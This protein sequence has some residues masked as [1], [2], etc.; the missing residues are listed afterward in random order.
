MRVALHT[1]LMTAILGSINPCVWC[2]KT[3]GDR[4][5]NTSE[6]LIQNGSFEIEKKDGRAQNWQF[7]GQMK[8]ASLDAG[9]IIKGKF[10]QRTEGTAGGKYTVSQKVAVPPKTE[11]LFTAYVRSDDRVVA[12]AGRLAMSYHKQGQWQKISG[13]IRSGS[14]NSVNITFRIGGLADKPVSTWIDNVVLQPIERPKL[15]PRKTFGKTTLVESGKP[16]TY[17]IY[18]SIGKY[19]EPAQRL[20]NIIGLHT[21]CEI[22]VIS[23]VEATEADRP[24]LKKL[25][26][27]SNLI[28]IGR[29]GINRAMWP[30]YGRFL[31]ATDGYYPGGDGYVVRTAA[32]VMHNGKN[33]LILGGSSDLGVTRA[34]ERFIKIIKD[35]PP[36]TGGTFTLPWLLDVG[37]GGKCKKRFEAENK[38]WIKDPLNKKLH[39]TSPPN[40]SAY[41]IVRTWYL[42]A[43]GYYWTGWPRY[44]QRALEYLKPVLK[45]RARTHHYLTEF[46][47]RTYD[48][49][50]DGDLFT[51]E[52]F[53]ALDDLVFEDFWKFLL[54]GDLDRMKAF[55]P[56]YNN[57]GLINRHEISPWTA[58]LKMAEFLHKYFDLEGDIKDLVEFRFSEKFHFFKNIVSERWGSSQPFLPDPEHE[59]EIVASLF[60]FALDCEFYEFFNNG[61]AR[62]AL[63]LDKINH[64]N[65]TLVWPGGRIDYPLSLGILAHYYKDGRYLALLNKSRMPDRTFQNRYDNGVHRY[66]PGPELDPSGLET[67]SGVRVPPAIPHNLNH[68]YRLRY[69]RYGLPKLKPEEALNFVSF[70][71]GFDK[72]DDYVAIHGM[73]SC[74]PPGVFIT[75]TS[76]GVNWFDAWSPNSF[77]PTT[78]RYFDHNAVSVV[79][80]DRWA[81]QDKPYSAVAAKDWAANFNR[82][83][84]AAFTLDPFMSTR[85]QRQVLWLQ[86]GLYVVRDNVTALE[87]GDFNIAVTWKPTG[88]PSWDGATWSST[89]RGAQLRITPLGADFLVNQNVDEHSGGRTKKLQF[90]QQASAKLSAGQ[91]LTSTTVLQARSPRKEPIYKGRLIAPDMLLLEPDRPDADPILV[92]WGSPEKPGIDSDAEVIILQSGIL[93]AVNAKTLAI[94]GK[95]VMTAASP[96]NVSL[97]FASGLAVIDND[98][99]KKVGQ[100]VFTATDSAATEAILLQDITQTRALP[101]LRSEKISRTL[102]EKIAAIAESSQVAK[103]P[104]QPEDERALKPEDN[105]RKWGIAW[106]YN[107]MKRPTLVNGV[108]RIN[109]DIIDLGSVVKLAEIRTETNWRKWKPE[110][111]PEKIWTALPGENGGTPALDSKLWKK[112]EQRPVWL[113]EV[114]IGN[115]GRANVEKKGHQAVYPENVSA[116]YIR[117]P[118]GHSLIFYDASDPAPR[119]PV[120]LEVEDLDNNGQPEIFAVSD[121]WP[122]FV[123]PG[124]RERDESWAIIR[125]DGSEINRHTAAINLQA[126]RLLDIDGSGRKRIVQAGLDAQLHIFEPDGSLLQHIDLYQMH[127]RFDE[128]EGRSN[129]RHPAGLY[130]M[131]YSIGLWRPDANGRRK[132]VVSRYCNFSFIDQQSRFEG[133]L[134]DGGYVTPGMLKYGIDFNGDGKEEQVCLTHGTVIHLD[135]DDTPTIRDPGGDVFYPEVYD[136]SYLNEP[137]AHDSLDGARVKIFKPLPWGNASAIRYILVVRENYLGIY[138][139]KLKKWA[140]TWVPDVQLSAAAI[141]RTDSQ[142]L[143]ILAISRDNLLWQI[144]WRD[145]I[146]GIE[147][148]TVR[149]LNQSVNAIAVSPE[150]PNLALVAGESGLYLLEGLDKLSLIAL[151]GCYDV[152]WL[153]KS[154][155]ATTTDGRVIRLDPLSPQSQ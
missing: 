59:E 135:G 17:I 122:L 94:D 125:P 11:M 83:G 73:N 120:R 70:R 152:K 91:S 96:V 56:P 134:L 31:C 119:C 2:E 39:Y 129:T 111:L 25:Y 103:A 64:L 100:I 143:Q 97:D 133:V 61:N 126:V 107:G 104:E 63:F 24:V 19:R 144:N 136:Y 131:P 81:D 140:F 113:P 71:S 127:Q 109:D 53:A 26:R 46:L 54:G 32:N 65:G 98:P 5:E 88:R 86:P 115:Y 76:H 105:T 48:M 10:S 47:V 142:T 18:P 101:K 58:D 60:R 149:P 138:D 145:K 141:V 33:H 80:T 69:R 38:L 66:V 146:D 9:E 82:S 72:N 85:W 137:D 110:T 22:P 154:A 50:D 21:G 40:D 36:R 79:R 128:I 74:Y 34:I 14:A 30:A 49:L 132:I 55:S 116:R 13:L 147:R 35:T 123:T 99:E 114:R 148:F 12:Q 102:T 51:P 93:K 8:S 84:G 42:N 108:R 67:F 16:N 45:D 15:A 6:N 57:I 29:L 27:D 41:G 95:T 92:C 121:M 52:Q 87:N 3:T 124:R 23:D 118:R 20:K 112:L 7:S 78:S 155:I 62:R 68:L 37:L 117:A 139:G 106:T 153:G 130:T 4:P 151:D 28:L 89:N 44:R 77:A 43:M 75:F 1:L 90:R 150:N